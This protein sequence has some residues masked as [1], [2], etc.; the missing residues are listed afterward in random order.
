MF[1]LEKFIADS[2]TKRYVSMFAADIEANILTERYVTF[3]VI[4][5]S[6]LNILH[7]RFVF[8]SFI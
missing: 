4:N 3:S 8:I 1:N 6:K 2:I 7:S 5:L